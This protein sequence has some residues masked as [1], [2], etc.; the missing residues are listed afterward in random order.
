MDIE[1]YIEELYA[2]YGKYG[3]PR[4]LLRHQFIIGVNSGLTCEQASIML[5]MTLGEE[6]DEEEIFDEHDMAIVLDITDEEA[7][8]EIEKYK[9]ELFGD[10]VESLQD[11][12]HMSKL[13][14]E[15]TQQ[16]L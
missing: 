7:H 11:K 6:S 5:R 2:K 12:V 15:R 10:E 9:V 14:W 1:G 8:K 13:I 3:I 4:W 16:L